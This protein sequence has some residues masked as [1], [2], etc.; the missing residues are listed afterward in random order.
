MYSVFAFSEKIQDFEGRTVH[1]CYH[2]NAAV[3]PENLWVGKAALISP[4]LPDRSLPAGPHI[5]AH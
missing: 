1:N 2:H 3:T 4:P 5:A